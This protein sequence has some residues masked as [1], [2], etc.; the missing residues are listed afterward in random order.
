[1]G[2]SGVA[3]LDRLRAL[4][5]E[6]KG[7]ELLQRVSALRVGDLSVELEAPAPTPPASDAPMLSQ[8]D[9]E[10]EVDRRV[11]VKLEGVVE[12]RVAKELA[13]AFGA[14]VP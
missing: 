4:L 9:I 2:A 5:D 12:R 1:M 13:D 14:S 7:R 11:Q 3:D 6:L 8:D 10:A